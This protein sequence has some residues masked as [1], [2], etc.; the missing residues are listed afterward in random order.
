M[1][2]H[3]GI[4]DLSNELLRI[5]LEHIEADPDKLVNID[6]R[7]YLSQESFRPPPAPTRDQVEDIGAFRR[8]C[9]RFSELGIPHQFARVTT[10]FSAKGFRRLE[11]IAE[12][13]H[14]A[15]HVKKFSYMVPYFYVEGSSIVFPCSSYT[16]YLYRVGRE[17]VRE[18]LPDLQAR[19]G[20][21]D[22]SNFLRKIN[23]QKEIVRSEE[24]LRVLKK[25]ISAF[26]SL[27]HVQILRVQDR[28]DSALLS[29]IRQHDDLTQLVELRWPP[30]CSHSTKTL[31][32]ALLAS[33]SPCSRF[34]SPMLSPQSAIILA[35]HLPQ[36]ISTLFERLTCLELHFDDGTDLDNRMLELSG[37]FKLVFFAAKNMQALHLGF[38]SHR[39]L[40]LPL[41]SIYHEVRW[42]KLVAFGVQGWRLDADEIINLARRHR[43][44]LK[45]LRLRDVL[46]KEGSMWKDVLAFL[47]NDMLRLDW[48]SLRRI[49]YTKKFDEQWA[50]TGA[51]MPDDPPGGASESDDESDN[52]SYDDG[53]GSVVE[54]INGTA[55]DTSSSEGDEAS[56]FDDEDISDDEHGPAAHEMDFPP[57]NSPDTPASAPWCNCNGQ[58]YPES[59]DDL[60]DDGVFVSNAQRKLWEKWVVRRCPEHSQR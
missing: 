18:L 26:T 5:V 20:S 33:R 6:R 56:I 34:S 10:R 59:T 2:K 50:V 35:E 12:Q 38:P 30:A 36:S 27:Q 58:S 22:I 53:R 55:H 52:M 28:E 13:A 15:K 3:T 54:S 43:E 9:K 21:L 24:D 16:A 7:A 8:T 57:L 11:G 32:E 41:E 40:S 42:E 48:V 31:G 37:L 45:G 17:Q 51:E 29:F 1:A 23:D 14:L 39:P 19:L 46:L 47:R 49:G 44:R 4:L 60:G 25:A